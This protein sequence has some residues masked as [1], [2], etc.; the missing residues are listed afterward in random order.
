MLRF[1]IYYWQGNLLG[2]SELLNSC[3]AFCLLCS[4]CCSKAPRPPYTTLII[5]LDLCPTSCPIHNLT[6]TC[7]YV[8]DSVRDKV[9][10]C[11]WCACVYGACV[12]GACVVYVCMVH[13]CMVHVCMVHVCM[14]H[15]YVC[16]YLYLLSYIF[17]LL[18]ANLHM[19][20]SWTCRQRCSS[21]YM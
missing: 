6:F 8:F 3:V 11:I 14:V 4:Q 1:T 16:M 20:C 10:V 5:M 7:T 21:L 17:D 18:K 19:A 12:Y 2:Q 13:V 15:V 9:H